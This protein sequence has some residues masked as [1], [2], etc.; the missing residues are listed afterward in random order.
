[1]FPSLGFKRIPRRAP[2]L[3]PRRAAGFAAGLVVGAAAGFATG[4]RA[5]GFVVFG[6]RAGFSAGLAAGFV[7]V[8]AADFLL[9]P[10]DAGFVVSVLLVA[11]A[12]AAAFGFDVVLRLAGL[13]VFGFATGAGVVLAFCSGAEETTAAAAATGCAGVA[14]CAVF[15]FAGLL[16]RPNTR[17][18]SPRARP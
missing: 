5:A 7:V 13:G 15:G 9:L 6:L 16:N 8:L 17:R 10:R 11:L 14:I 4:L 3:R 2:P 1:M 18:T 12:L